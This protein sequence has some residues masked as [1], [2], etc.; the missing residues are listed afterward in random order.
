LSLEIDTWQH[1]R[2]SCTRRGDALENRYA[3]YSANEW[4]DPM[5]EAPS[6]EG[7][8]LVSAVPHR[9]GTGGGVLEG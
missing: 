2:L 4:L 8:F 5:K 3:W 6:N 7:A 1:V 9:E